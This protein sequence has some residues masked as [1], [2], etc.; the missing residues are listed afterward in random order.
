MNYKF[1]TADVLILRRLFSNTIRFG[2]GPSVYHYWYRKEFDDNSI[3]GRGN[4][5]SIGLDSADIFTDKTY[6]GAKSIFTVNNLNSALFP[7]R[8]IQWYNELLVYRGMEKDANSLTRVSSDMQIY[9]SLSD[10]DNL[11]GV[12]RLGGGHIFSK[13]F[14]YFQALGLGQNTYLRGFRKNRF[15]GNSLAYGSVELRA[16]LFNIKSYILPGQFGLVGFN[17]VG[18]VWLRDEDSRKWHNTPGAGFYFIPYD[19]VIISGTA[20]FSPEE[21]LFNITVGT[22]LGITL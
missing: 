13:E 21:T 12:L 20:A 4:Y 18:R 11:V 2:I 14:E 19:M 10:V 9:A 16:K 22:R 15:T 8:G 5:E 17:D 7:T 1:A 6:V 3:F